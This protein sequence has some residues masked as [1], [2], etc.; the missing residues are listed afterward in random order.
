MNTH[1]DKINQNKS[2]S[3]VNAVAQKQN[4]NESTFQFIDN[5]P[6]AL[7]QRKLQEAVKNSYQAKRTAQLR[8]TANINKSFYP[9]ISVAERHKVIQRF[10]SEDEIRIWINDAVN[11]Y[12]DLTKR[13][14]E[15][16]EELD[17]IELDPNN[18]SRETLNELKK[19][20]D[21]LTKD[22]WDISE[23]VH[24]SK[25][26]IP[27][28]YYKERIEPRV[29]ELLSEQANVKIRFEKVWRENQVIIPPW[30][31]KRGGF[32]G[33]GRGGGFGGSRGRGF[34]GGY[35]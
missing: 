3:A 14:K 7:A 6:E 30:P 15:I 19:K 16:N 22:A 4:R 9:Q 26:E 8:A 13:F 5:R 27:P 20:S 28:D 23:W 34:G 17:Q 1:A 31:P 32:S 2:L 33:A 21:G 25:N 29:S 35:R 11:K 10:K 24:D 12:F 18:P